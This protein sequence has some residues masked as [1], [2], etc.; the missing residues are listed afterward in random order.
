MLL[1]KQTILV[2]EDEAS[3]GLALQK[4]LVKE[5]Y[6][7][8]VAANGKTG[9][10]L[11]L[12]SHP[13]LILLDIMMPVM[14]GLT[15]LT[16]LREDAWGKKAKVVVLTNL[17]DSK[18]EVDFREK[19]VLDFLIKSNLKLAEVYIKIKLIIDS[20]NSKK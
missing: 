15:M 5:G 2:I 18:K 1:D 16:N 20:A 6:D 11:A 13:D 14:D 4:K 17:V 19:G 7:V 10:D 9:L 3:I 8:T 12:A